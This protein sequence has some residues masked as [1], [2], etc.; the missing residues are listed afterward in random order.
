M[1]VAT[2]RL[3]VLYMHE[4]VEKKPGA[5]K[6]RGGVSSVGGR[7]GLVGHV[8]DVGRSA[9]HGNGKGHFRFRAGLRNGGMLVLRGLPVH[10][11]ER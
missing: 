1:I 7:R 6:W 4:M 3:C 8:T 2:P 11:I 10:T 9:F 5:R